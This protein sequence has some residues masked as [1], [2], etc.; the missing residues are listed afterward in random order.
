MLDVLAVRKRHAKGFKMGKYES[1]GWYCAKGPIDDDSVLTDEDLAILG[2]LDDVADLTNN[3]NAG[4]SGNDEGAP[5][6]T[7]EDKLDDED[8]DNLDAGSDE[9]NKPPEGEPE[10][11]NGDNLVPQAR[12]D[13]IV[14]EREDLRRENEQLRQQGGPAPA[15]PA[16]ELDPV[17]A[18]IANLPN[19]II[20]GGTGA[21]AQYNGMT[22]NELWEKN[23]SV[24]HIYQTNRTHQ[25]QT[26]HREK[27]EAAASAM[28]QQE[29]WTLEFAKDYAINI[30][31][32]DIDSVMDL[33]PEEWEKVEAEIAAIDKWGKSKGYNIQGV[34]P[35]ALAAAKAK[36]GQGKS[37]PG[38]D[39]AERIVK[40]IK[41]AAPSIDGKVGSSS[42]AGYDGFINLS[43][44]ELSSKMDDMSDAD[45]SKFLKNA[46]AK[47][48]DKYPG[49]DWSD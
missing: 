34:S 39:K 10:P 21:Y 27:A 30:L 11:D 14:K 23:K 20:E 16:Q 9:E 49:I 4:E 40:K 32:H 43:P 36:E 3:D 46:P 6:D 45:M 41:S 33:T 7:D 8:I 12:V 44:A 47:F 19:E 1:L 29:A 18:E 42:V 17:A 15:Q 31:K 2:E 28:N 48:K 13:E 24:A 25:I 37:A 35:L 26:I 5:E 38:K 22:L